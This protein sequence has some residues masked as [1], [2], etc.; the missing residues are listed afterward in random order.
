L[1]DSEES[2]AAG[3]TTMNKHGWFLKARWGL[4]S[5]ALSV[6]A[7]A[8]GREPPR[9]VLTADPPVETPGERAEDGAAQSDVERGQAYSAAGDYVHAQA[10]F[11]RAVSV[12]PTATAWTYLGITAEKLKDKSG[13][14]EAYKEALAIDPTFPEAAQNLGAIYLDDPP[15]P[16]AAIAV[17]KPAVAKN[18]DPALVQNL[19]LAYSLKGDVANAAKTYELALKTTNDPRIRFAYGSLLFDNKQ[20][21]K[22]AEQ[23]KQALLS[24]KD[25]APLLV[26]I[27]RILGATKAYAEC[28]RAFDRAIALKSSDPEWFVRR[29]TCRHE[30]KDEEGAAAD[31]EQG[32]KVAPKFAPAHYYLGLSLVAQK[33]RMNGIAELEKA[34]ILGAGTPIG[35]AA[36]DKVIALTKLP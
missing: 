27:G 7:C 35:K 14:E 3:G 22:A 29:G 26:S 31:F 16:D 19:G 28:V 6:A 11:R 9:T 33:R 12:K 8:A 1:V 15:H 10:A 18:G 21:E 30:L 20:P 25:D 5:G 4:A 13:A 32:I 17:L 23:M 36:K 34:A 2:D 24:A